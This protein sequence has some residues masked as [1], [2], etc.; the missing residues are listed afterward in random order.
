MHA[1]IMYGMPIQQNQTALRAK[2][3]RKTFQLFLVHVKSSKSLNI[4][5]F[6][7]IKLN[8]PQTLKIDSRQQRPI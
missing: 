5:I 2:I 1:I 4:F 8:N 7:L 3:H 6:G